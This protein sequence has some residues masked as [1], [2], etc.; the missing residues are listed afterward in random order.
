VGDHADDELLEG[1]LVDG[2]FRIVRALASGAM[3]VV[4][5]ARHE[6][7]GRIVALKVLRRELLT[8]A[9][10]AA[11][12]EQEAR[13]AS[14][15]GHRNI[16]D[17]FDL[18]RCA[19]GRPYMA[20]E[21]LEGATLA[22]RLA[23]DGMIPWPQAILIGAQLLAALGAAHDRG[24]V[25]RDLKPENLFL[26]DR[27]DG[28]VELKVLDFGISKVSQPGIRH[29]GVGTTHGLV[30]G[31]VDYMAPEQARGQT[32]RIDART[33]LYAAGVVLY[34]MLCGRPPFTEENHVATL[35]AILEHRYE[36]VRSLRPDVPAE[37]A[38]LVERAI[39]VDPADRFQSAAAMR[40]A[41]RALGG[42]TIRTPP[43]DIPA[44]ESRIDSARFSPSRME[45]VRLDTWSGVVEPVSP[46]PEPG[47]PDRELGTMLTPVGGEVAAEPEPERAP[48]YP[49]LPEPE[50]RSA[51]SLRS[52]PSLRPS[53]P[54]ALVGAPR[55]TKPLPPL[56]AELPRVSQSLPPLPPSERRTPPRV[57]AP[58]VGRPFI[59][60]L[61]VAAM[62][63][64][65][66]YLYLWQRAPRTP[67]LRLDLTPSDAVVRL[68][69]EVTPA[70]SLHLTP[71]GTHVL[72]VDAPGHVSVERAFTARR[73]GRLAVHL[74]HTLPT[75]GERDAAALPVDPPPPVPAPARSW[76]ELDL[77]VAQLER[78][79]ACLES[80]TQRDC[81]V[82]LRRELPGLT[83]VE[84]SLDAYEHALA[85]RDE[86]HTVDVAK[87]EAALRTALWVARD[88][89]DASELT[90][91]APEEQ[92]DDWQAR[93][94]LVV[95]RPGLR[96]G[97]ERDRLLAAEAL[98]LFRHVSDPAVAD[99]ASE[100]VAA[101]R[102]HRHALTF[103][104]RLVELYNASPIKLPEPPGEASSER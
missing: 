4:Y 19:D 43:P 76:R 51:P 65:G 38:A 58:A 12:F 63:A 8:S 35:A 86:G 84:H 7:L 80:A 55:T 97:A 24:V 34:E 10:F 33:D 15:I 85:E 66:W 44:A 9:D 49:H 75:V 95:A 92:N 13:A 28:T 91:L 98:E 79:A 81:I 48:P 23:V 94:A 30:L 14:A 72:L 102:N 78:L 96:P 93:R 50:Q 16:V 21:L 59:V 36:P 25:H 60:G 11:R 39:A 2:R 90:L 64:G 27:V 42:G 70:R 88:D 100:A 73:A 6:T 37:L 52:S 45:V 74:P 26:V 62:V 87:A 103:Y 1:E 77:G 68:D 82:A 83:P 89:L 54:P 20:M 18:G 57:P 3:G 41:L 99:T 32:D 71:A 101:L 47:A 67:G 17:V 5:I 104:N 29:A 40:E 46:A 53:S 22:D 31:T 61:I 69:G 56:P